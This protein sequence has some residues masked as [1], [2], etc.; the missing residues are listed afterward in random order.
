MA[1]Q[2]CWFNDIRPF[3]KSQHPNSVGSKSSWLEGRDENMKTT[4]PAPKS[5]VGRGARFKRFQTQTSVDLCITREIE[6]AV[7]TAHRMAPSTTVHTPVQPEDNI[8]LVRGTSRGWVPVELRE[9]AK[10]KDTT[11]SEDQAA[12]EEMSWGTGDG[13]NTSKN[14]TLSA[15]GRYWTA[16]RRPSLGDYISLAAKKKASG[17]KKADGYSPVVSKER[18]TGTLNQGSEDKEVDDEQKVT[19]PG[20]CCSRYSTAP[21][22][23]CSGETSFYSYGSAPGDVEDEI[24]QFQV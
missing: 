10:K 18:A 7:G 3:K 1:S 9:E 14:L 21:S 20:I 19:P 23:F 22:T 15:C 5:G 2:N 11:I 4:S 12:S 16:D 13:R 8:E 17:K 6:K 24:E